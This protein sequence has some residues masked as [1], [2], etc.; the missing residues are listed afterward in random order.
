MS[1][2][3]GMADGIDERRAQWRRELPA[4]DTT[5]MAILGRARWIAHRVRSDVDA[6]FAKFGLD[7]GEFDVIATLLRAGS[8]YRL[9]PTDLYQSLLISSGGLTNRLDRLEHKRLLRRAAPDADA[10]SVPVEL[11]PEGRACAEAA[12]REDMRVEG[13]LLSTLTRA[14]QST[15]EALLRKLVVSLDR[16]GDTRAS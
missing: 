5:G 11:T 2:Q 10:R 1:R 4:V 12:F 14:E 6:V 7:A 16:P 15:L 9:R 3:T 13:E 8:P